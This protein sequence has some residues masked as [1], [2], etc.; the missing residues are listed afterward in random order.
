MN[1]PPPASP[2]ICRE[3]ALAA[4]QRGDMATAEQAFLRLLETQPDDAEALQFLATRQL[5]RGH[6]ERAIEL[7]LAAHRAQPQDAAILHRLGEVQM[8]AGELEA[9]ADSLRKGLQVAPGMFVARLRVGGETHVWEEGRCVTFDDTSEHEAW[10]RSDQTRVV[11][12]LDSWNPDLGEAEQAAVTDLV[13]AI[14][15]FNQPGGTAAQP[16][17]Q[18]P[19]GSRAG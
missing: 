10:N 8:L 7:L 5:G 19:S 18:E 12:I 6:M 13:A 15:D 2:A 16:R 4:W 11:P 17:L 3:Q 9:A 1:K 14:G